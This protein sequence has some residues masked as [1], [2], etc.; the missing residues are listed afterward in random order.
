MKKDFELIEHTADIGLRAYG[1]DIAQTFVNAA[2]GMFSLI[3]DTEKVQ[4]RITRDISVSASDQEALLVEWLNELVFLFDS[5]QLLF[6]TYYIRFINDTNLQAK[7]CGEKADLTRHEIKIGIKSATY[8][9]LK[10]EKQRDYYQAQ[11]IF[12]I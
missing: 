4:E 1:I 3:T 7:A 9:M 12:D 8:H 6:T 2:R 10:I 11:V 5:E